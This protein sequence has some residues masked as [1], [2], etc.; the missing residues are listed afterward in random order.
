[1]ATQ[2]SSIQKR[3]K[4]MA[5]AY[6]RFQAGL[7]K[8]QKEIKHLLVELNAELEQDKINRLKTTIKK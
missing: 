2:P 8:T 5:E 7:L 3:A 6:Q 1:M 4:N